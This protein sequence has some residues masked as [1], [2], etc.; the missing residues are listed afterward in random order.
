M[1]DLKP[2]PKCGAE[3][4]LV[5]KGRMGVLGGIKCVNCKF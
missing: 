4:P 2:C 5:V 3:D 1:S